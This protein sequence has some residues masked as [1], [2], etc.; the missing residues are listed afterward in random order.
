MPMTTQKVKGEKVAIYARIST[1]RQQQN[2]TID[3]QLACLQVYVVKQGWEL[4]APEYIFRND[5]YSEAKL[6]HPDLERLRE[7]TM[8]GDYP[9]IYYP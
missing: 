2:Q 9:S 5:G 3:Q 8:L 6:A 4:L 7:Q 1:L